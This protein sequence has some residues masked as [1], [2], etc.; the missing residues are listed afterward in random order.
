MHPLASEIPNYARTQ[1]LAWVTLFSLLAGVD[2]V[3]L[4]QGGGWKPLAAGC[5]VAGA[6]LS[7]GPG[8]LHALMMTSADRH[9]HSCG[10]STGACCARRAWVAA[11]AWSGIA[12]LWR[13]G[14]LDSAARWSEPRVIGH[15][16]TICRVF[17][18]FGW[19]AVVAGGLSADHQI[20][21][22]LVPPARLVLDCRHQAALW[23]AAS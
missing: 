4:L 12:G 22:T 15:A 7:K 16:Y 1:D 9:L 19:R 3:A 11:L 10:R 18:E 8:F 5:V 23:A 17:W 2:G 21:E 14:L 6:T 20:A 13:S